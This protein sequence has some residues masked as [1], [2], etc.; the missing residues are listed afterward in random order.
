M[1]NLDK[2]KF[3]Y[4]IDLILDFKNK[5]E[6]NAE[7]KVLINIGF[8]NYLTRKL[9]FNGG[10][11]YDH[12]YPIFLNDKNIGYAYKYNSTIKDYSKFKLIDYNSYLKNGILKNII[13]L[14]S[15]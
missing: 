10:I 14:F 3:S 9:L 13:L 8:I 1:G 5:N 2:N 12:I 4:N 15:Y 7:L 6:F 11:S